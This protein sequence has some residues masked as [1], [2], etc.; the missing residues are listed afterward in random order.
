MGVRDSQFNLGVLCARG[1]GVAQDLGQA[2]VWFS[3]AAAQGDAEAARK[4]EEVAGK[5][6]ADSLAAAADQLSRFKPLQPDP[7]ANDT[8]PVSAS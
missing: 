5:M 3:L 8:A 6:D 1:L 4:R 2:W 7:T